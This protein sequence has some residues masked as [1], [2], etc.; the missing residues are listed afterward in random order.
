MREHLNLLYVMCFQWR[1]QRAHVMDVKSLLLLLLLLQL[2][3]RSLILTVAAQTV[4]HAWARSFAGSIQ[5][6]QVTTAT[7]K[8]MQYET[9]KLLAPKWSLVRE[10]LMA[11]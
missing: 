8:H 3:A 1:Q 9:V 6:V 10:R 2:Q 4:H 7:S 11:T 5:T